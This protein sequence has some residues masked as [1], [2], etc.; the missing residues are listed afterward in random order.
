MVDAELDGAAQDDATG[1]GVAG[2]AGEAVGGQ[3][4]GPEADA[5]DRKV[6]AEQEVA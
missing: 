1:F 3:P 6:A 4:H 2:R 5:V